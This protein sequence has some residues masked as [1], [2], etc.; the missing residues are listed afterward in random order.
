[1][2]LNKHILITLILFAVLIYIANKT[3]SLEEGYE[4]LFTLT[5]G[6]ADGGNYLLKGQFPISKNGVSTKQYS[7]EWKSYPIFSNPSFKQMT[8]NLRY[9]TNP[10]IARES[11]EDLLDAFYG[12]K[13]TKSN[14]VNYGQVKPILTYNEPRVGYWN[15]SVDVM[16]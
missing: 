9:F 5:P 15:T 7:Q 2:R 4:N 13:S 11:P 10:S 6:N 16:Y 3:G 8:N 12:S 1:M 14:I